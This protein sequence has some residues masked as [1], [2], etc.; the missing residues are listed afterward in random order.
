MQTDQFGPPQN[1]FSGRGLLVSGA[2]AMMS[3]MSTTNKLKVNAT[4]DE[5]AL[6]Y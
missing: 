2:H 4:T 1:Y 3:A 5:G 6:T